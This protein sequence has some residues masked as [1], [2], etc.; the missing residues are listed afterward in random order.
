MHTAK[1]VSLTTRRVWRM[2]TDAP[3]G[4]WVESNAAHL[5][6]YKHSHEDEVGWAISSLDLACGLDVFEVDDSVLTELS[7]ERA[8]KPS[9]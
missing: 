9:R 1:S 3:R 8:T 7:S 2:T 6:P 5:A 4:E